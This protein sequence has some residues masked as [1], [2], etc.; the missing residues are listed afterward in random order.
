MIDILLATYNGEKYIAEQIESILHQTFQ[1]FR[2]ILRDDGSTDNTLS[3]ARRYE[4]E[5]P[6][7]IRVF[8]NQPATGEARKNFF[9]LLSDADS[10][11][12][13]FCD[14]DDIWNPDKIEITLRRMKKLE[15]EVA[16]EQEADNENTGDGNRIPLLV[17]TDLSVV[18]GEGK[19]LAASF[20][21]YM[22]LPVRKTLNQLI[23][24]N[25][26]TGC[27]VMV[28]RC[29]VDYMKQAEQIEDVLMHDHWAALIASVFGR[30]VYL[31]IPTMQYRQHGNNSVGA[32]DARSISYLY[33]RFRKGRKQFRR[34]LLHSARQIGY[35]IKIY[36]PLPSEVGIAELLTAYSGLR[37]M[38]KLQRI[39]FYVHYRVFK[40]GIIRCIMQMLWG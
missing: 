7:Q 22:N 10:D 6:K 18:D 9:R 21:R 27:T 20:Q 40:Q 26:V 8:Q 4:A 19:M 15:S 39:R 36:G 35:F 3:I 5:Y 32:K 12:V 34:E 23:I 13:M 28:N 33:G 14:Q 24:Q 17:H 29:L 30:M 11:Y 2:I 25:Y 37:K 1:D 16:S 31:D 38:N